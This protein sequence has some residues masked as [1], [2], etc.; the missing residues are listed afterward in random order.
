MSFFKQVEGEAAIL[1][2][3]GVYKQVDLYT[4]GGFLYAKVAGGFVRLSRDGSTSKPK[5]RLDHMSWNGAL[6]ADP[7]GR[8]C[9]EEANISRKQSIFGTAY[10]QKLLGAPEEEKQTT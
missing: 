8:L 1:S 5:L 2:E 10:E 3:N 6:Y 4:R 7:V 9:T